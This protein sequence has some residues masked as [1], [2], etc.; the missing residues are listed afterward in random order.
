MKFFVFAG[1]MSADLCASRAIAQ[2]KAPIELIGVGGPHLQALG[3]RQVLSMKSF[4]T[5][6]FSDVVKRLPKIL[7]NFRIVKNCIL[8]ENPDLVL[9]IDQPAL[10][11]RI[12]KSLRTSGY[13][14]KIVQL[15]APSVW[16][17]NPKRADIMAKYFDLLLTLFEF[18]PKYFA[19]TSLKTVFVGHPIAELIEEEKQKPIQMILPKPILAIFPGSRPDEIK[20]NLPKQL[21]AAEIVKNRIPELHILVSGRDVPFES[22][23]DL[24]RQSKIALAKSGTVTLELALFG[25][26]T[27]VTYELT[28]INRFIGKHILGLDKMPHY[29]IANIAAQKEIFPE[30]IRPPNSAH[31]IA[32]GLISLYDVP[33]VDFALPSV[34]AS[35]RIA[36]ELLLILK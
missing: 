18:E 14:G 12:A 17:Y 11:I 15:V 13:K 35:K 22:R 23:Y 9:F 28:F 25:V 2:I 33:K 20:R 27:A 30:F 10:S 6:G 4:Q 26:P 16:A 24:M 29:C 7:K 19:H 32:Q 21:E 5:M 1:E 31:D 36:E 8:A 3:Q 34:A